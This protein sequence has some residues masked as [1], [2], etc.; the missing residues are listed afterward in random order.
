MDK[1]KVGINNPLWK[2]G[3]VNSNGYHRI[4][5]NGRHT[6]KHKIIMEKH[7]G[8]KLRKNE[9]VHHINKNKLDNRIENLKVMTILEHQ[10]IHHLG[11]KYEK[12]PARLLA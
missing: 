11:K 6:Y 12:A 1:F 9:V 10:R 2:G 5:V 7:L 8:R 3:W 4:A